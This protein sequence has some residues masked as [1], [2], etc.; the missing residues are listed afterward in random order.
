M[1]YKFDIKKMT[2]QA[3]NLALAVLTTMDEPVEIEKVTCEEMSEMVQKHAFKL[4][5]KWEYSKGVNYT[6]RKYLRTYECKSLSYGN[7]DESF[8]KSKRKET[9]LE[10]FSIK[11]DSK[12]VTLIISEDE[13]ETC[14][15]ESPA[16]HKGV[17]TRKWEPRND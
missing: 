6:N 14:A 16:F 4:G 3:N 11:P 7:D 13:I 12:M 1:N 2:E 10:F 8:I 9:G 5:Y 17:V 15:K